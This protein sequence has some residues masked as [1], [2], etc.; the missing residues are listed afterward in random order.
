MD[1]EQKLAAGKCDM[2]CPGAPEL[3]C[4]GY[5]TM[6][7]HQTG[8]VPLVPS[9][10]GEVSLSEV[11]LLAIDDTFLKLPEWLFFINT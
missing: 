8:F 6:D 11:Y 5:L 4:G 1:P 3:T 2:P 10:L 9:K 7:I